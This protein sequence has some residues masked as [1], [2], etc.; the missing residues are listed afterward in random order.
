MSPISKGFAALAVIIALSIARP[1][2]KASSP[3]RT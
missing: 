2:H 1:A 3:R